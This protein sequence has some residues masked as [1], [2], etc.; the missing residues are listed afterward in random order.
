MALGADV[1][2]SAETIIIVIFKFYFWCIVFF[3]G[4]ADALCDLDSYPSFII[5]S[6]MNT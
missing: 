3:Y 6:L 1:Q 2:A 4:V 5:A